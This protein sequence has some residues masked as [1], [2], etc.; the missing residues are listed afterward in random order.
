MGTLKIILLY[1]LHATT[2]VRHVQIEHSVSVVTDRWGEWMMKHQAIVDVSQVH[3]MMKKINNAS[4]VLTT[5]KHAQVTQSARHALH[6]VK[7]SIM[8]VN[9]LMDISKGETLNVS[10][11][12]IHVSHAST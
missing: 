11:V 4:L 1:V 8:I 9:A 3:T 5:V 12:I 7:L 6:H 10:C 2:V